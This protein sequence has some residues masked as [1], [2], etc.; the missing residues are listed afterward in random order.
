MG[1]TAGRI[2][3]ALALV[4]LLG[5]VPSAAQDMALEIVQRSE[6]LMRGERAVGSYR[7]TILRPG[8][9]RVL[10]FDSW[11][12]GTRQSFI[13]IKAP[14][15]ERGVTFLKLGREM[16]QYVPRINRVVKLPP[17]MMMQSWMGSGFTNDD[18]V[19]SSSL[20]EDYEHSLVGTLATTEG[21][22]WQI[23]LKTRPEAPVAWDRM[24]MWIRTADYLPVKAEFYNERAELVRTMTYSEFRLVGGRTLPSRMELTEE[25][26][27]DRKTILDIVSMS[28]D[29]AIDPGVFTQRN[30]RRSR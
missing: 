9:Q 2:P 4:A 30:L 27:A 26:F 18:L 24:L 28:F 14:A 16:W 3:G 29:E 17:S 20:V 13:L 19:R 1:W 8:W 25:R 10:E 11:V 21:E 6:A 5:S 22:A 7:I 15:K 23:E 12:D